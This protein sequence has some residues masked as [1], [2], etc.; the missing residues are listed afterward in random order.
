MPQFSKKKKEPKEVKQRGIPQEV[1]DT[2]KPFVEGLEKDEEGRLTFEEGESI[3]QG[4]KALVAAGVEL[5][6]YVKARKPRGSD[7]ELVFEII[8]RTEF[9]EAKRM[10]AERGAKLKGKPR[11]K[12][13]AKKKS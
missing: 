6:K 9:M 13:A 1:I 3:V 7:N 8:T 5:N 11:A 4:R 10:A 12:A 2:Y